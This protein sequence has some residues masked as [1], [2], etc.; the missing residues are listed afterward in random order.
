MEHKQWIFQVTNKQILLALLA[1]LILT[2]GKTIIFLTT[3]L[4]C[5]IAI[6]YSG[7]L[8]NMAIPFNPLQNGGEG[9]C[10]ILPF[11]QKNL[12]TYLKIPDFW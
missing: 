6:F 8:E 2:E 11:T 7:L 4:I 3:N 12:N 10:D 1:F 9:G 5:I